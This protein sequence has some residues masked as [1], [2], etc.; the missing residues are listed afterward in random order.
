MDRF[1]NDEK[2][3]CFIL[4]TRSGGMG[5]NLTGADTGAIITD[6]FDYLVHTLTIFY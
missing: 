5:I 2:I 3:F 6:A 4:S 1:N